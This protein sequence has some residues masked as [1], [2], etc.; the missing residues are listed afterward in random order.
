MRKGQRIT[1]FEFI[2]YNMY[3]DPQLKI[4]RRS[5]PRSETQKALEKKRMT[6][7]FPTLALAGTPPEG[8]EITAYDQAHLAVYLSLLYAAGEGH[9]EEKMALDIL[10]IDATLEPERA[11]HTLHSHLTRARWLAASGYKSLLEDR[12]FQDPLSA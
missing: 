1:Y 12:P 5:F 6:E 3:S 10:G 9:S 7:A 11:Y 4:R 8:E 2:N